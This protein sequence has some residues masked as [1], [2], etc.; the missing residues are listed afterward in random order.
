MKFFSRRGPRRPSLDEFLE[1]IRPELLALPFPEPAP[2]LRDRIVASRQAGIRTLLPD[3]TDPRRPASRLVVPVAIAVALLILS[4]PVGL[5][6]SRSGSQGADDVTSGL[7]G[8][9]LA[10]GQVVRAQRPALAPI[11]IVAPAKLHPMSL[12][13]T[14]RLR[15]SGRVI[16]ERRVAL[17]IAAV[18]VSNIPAWRLTS[19]DSYAGTGE[20]RAA[21]ETAYVARADLGLLRRTIHVTPYGRFQRINVWQQFTP[22]SVSGRMNTEGPSIG[23]GRVF[24]RRLPLTFAPYMTV[25][26]TPAFLM[27]VRLAPGWSGSASLLGW[28]VRDDDFFV[29]VEMRVEGKETISVPAGRFECWRLSLRFAGKELHYWARTSD[30]LGVRVLS[31]DDSANRTHEL[32]LTRER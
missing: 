16:S 24:A 28:A 21:V 11:K 4:V 12:E 23:A 22:D 15:V 7:M 27:G 13:F 9:A 32:V 30:G 8:G 2:A 25:V 6:R 29:P 18:S 10:Y 19:H 26:T 14:R 20:Q 1:A 5:W 3:V 31:S 17:E